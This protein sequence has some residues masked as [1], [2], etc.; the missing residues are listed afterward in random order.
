MPFPF[1]CSPVIR[2]CPWK[3]TQKE[4]KKRKENAILSFIYSYFLPEKKFDNMTLLQPMCEFISWERKKNI[5]ETI[6]LET[7]GL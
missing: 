3:K 5:T 1:P 4:K 2:E 6:P 7:K